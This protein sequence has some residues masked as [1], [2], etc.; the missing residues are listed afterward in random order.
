MFGPDV[1]VAPVLYEN[2]RERSVYLPEGNWRNI[3]DGE[4]LEGGRTI[5]APAPYEAIPVFVKAGSE[6]EKMLI[7]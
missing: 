2:V 5:T 1:L 4:C 6:V 3:N 7:P